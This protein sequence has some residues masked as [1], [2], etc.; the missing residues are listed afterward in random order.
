MGSLIEKARK[1]GV[2]SAGQGGVYQCYLICTNGHIC[3][4]FTETR[5][6][7]QPVEYQWLIGNWSSNRYAHTHT[8][9]IQGKREQDIMRKLKI[10]S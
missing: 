2:H 8:H 4:M 5:L 7:R 6:S 9:T 10:Y 1:E 3:A